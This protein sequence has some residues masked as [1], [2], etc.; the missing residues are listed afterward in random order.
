MESDKSQKS[1]DPLEVQLPGGER[2]KGPPS[3]VPSKGRESVDGDKCSRRSQTSR[4]AESIEKVY[5]VV[6]KNR[7]Q[8]IAE[9]AEIS[10]ATCQWIHTKDF[11]MHRGCQ[12]IVPSMLNEDQS[13]D[14]VKSA[15]QA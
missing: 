5:E 4:T 14:A 11:N 3:K 15:S 8:T 6:L 9:S 12:H 1:I 10:S 13:A 2:K 7:L